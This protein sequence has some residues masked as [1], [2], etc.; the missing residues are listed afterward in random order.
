MAQP[1]P[2]NQA[3]GGIR[4]L[5]ERIRA[6]LRRYLLLECLAL[7]LALLVGWVAISAMFDHGLFRFLGLDLA[8][9]APPFVRTWQTGPG[10]PTEAG[11]RPGLGAGKAAPRRVW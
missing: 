3:Q 10:F 11:C 7:A 6:Q 1:M 2:P 8:L 4:G 9:D 5:L